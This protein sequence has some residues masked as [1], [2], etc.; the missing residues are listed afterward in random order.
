MRPNSGGTKPLFKRLTEAEVA[1]KKSKGLCFRCDNKYGPGHRCP[2][3]TLHVL[4]VTEGE[5]DDEERYTDEHAH[6][7]MVEVSAKSVLGLT[8]PRT[9]KIRGRTLGREA[10]GLIDSGATH[11]FLSL[12]V[13]EPLRLPVTGTHA[14]G[15]RLGN[16]TTEKSYGVC[17]GI[18]L[19]LPELLVTEDFFPLELGSTDV[20]LGL[21]WLRKLGNTRVNWQAL[22]MTFQLEGTNI[23]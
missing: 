8:T 7:D 9:M 20:I 3:K 13:V 1:E 12:K 4:L 18:K 11:N 16:G 17:K 21:T 2:E 22:T 15:V 6:L 19:Q 10:V 23:T 14:T 5:G